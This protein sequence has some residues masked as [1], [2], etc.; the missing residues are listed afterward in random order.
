MPGKGRQG[1]YGRMISELFTYIDGGPLSNVMPHFETFDD[2][3]AFVHEYEPQ[4]WVPGANT[5]ACNQAVLD[6]FAQ[7]H[8]HHPLPRELAEALITS[9]WCDGQF[10]CIGIE[11]PIPHWT[12]P[13]RPR[14]S[15]APWGSA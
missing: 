3:V 13:V 12:R 7:W 11:A 9:F 8:P 2:W 15:V 14:R 10:V 6:K 5:R 4:P 1:R